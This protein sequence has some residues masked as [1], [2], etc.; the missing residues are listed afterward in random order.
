MKIRQ[1][2]VWRWKQVPVIF[3]WSLLLWFPWFY[4]QSQRLVPAM[5]SAL[6]MVLVLLAHES[7]HALAARWRRVRV[8]ALHIHLLQGRCEHAQPYREIDD[9]LIAW[10]G[11]L[12]QSVLLLLVLAVQQLLALTW[13]EGVM[14]AGPAIN[15]LIFGNLLWIAFNLLPIAPLDG[16]LAWRIVP[17]LR[18]PHRADLRDAWRELWRWPRRRGGPPADAPLSWPAALKKPQA[19]APE[20]APAPEPTQAQP[21]ADTVTY[22]LLKRLR[23]QRNTPPRPPAGRERSN[24]EGEGDEP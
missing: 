21:S 20:Q 14:L 13:P 22:E 4:L 1:S 6:A 23:E 18:G 16:H 10:G 3:H 11:V 12:A 2:L 19:K 17:L 15:T 9:V 24:G 5:Q 7:G 8:H